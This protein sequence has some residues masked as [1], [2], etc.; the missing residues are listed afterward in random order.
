MLTA[1]SPA[2]GT[3]E[4]YWITLFCHSDRKFTHTHI[5][6]QFNGKLYN[7][8]LFFYWKLIIKKN[9]ELK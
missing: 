6:T 2:D 8:N 7:K 4:G 5:H 9:N 1:Q 3:T